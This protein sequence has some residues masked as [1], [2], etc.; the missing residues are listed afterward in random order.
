MDSYS[1]VFEE[2][3]AMFL[4]LNGIRV[5]VSEARPNEV[6]PMPEVN[7]K[8]RR[9]IRRSA[10]GEQSFRPIEDELAALVPYTRLG[11]YMPLSGA[12]VV[13]SPSQ[14]AAALRV[15]AMLSPD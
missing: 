12:P 3:A 15:W 2:A 14:V 9:T 6:P 10:D 5:E 8:N 1:H 11:H 4:P 13:P 7:T